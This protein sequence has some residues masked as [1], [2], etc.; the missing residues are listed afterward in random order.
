LTTR[1]KPARA[2]FLLSVLL[3]AIAGLWILK[4]AYPG[5]SAR[6]G[7]VASANLSQDPPARTM[8]LNG[9]IRSH[10]YESYLEIG[11]GRR[12]GNFDLI[13][14]RTRIGV[15]P[16]PTLHAAYQMTSDE[17]FAKNPASFDLIFIDGLHRADQV[18]RDILN[19]LRVL[20]DQGTIV[21]HDCNPI[22]EALQVVPRQADD[23]TGDVWKAWVRLRASRA[24]LE[25]FVVDIETGCGIIRRGRQET[26][27]LPEQL[28]YQPL[29]Q[30]RKQLLNLL[31]ADSGLEKLL[32][33]SGRGPR[34][35]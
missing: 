2:I 19:S 35:H 29:E 10:S 18:E 26:V 5:V 27:S 30:H 28:D 24:D 20:N 23:W 12:E 11:Q 34:D 14:C 32:G 17:F 9:L 21:V 1:G 33:P 4:T 7:V 15:D 16:D 3:N 31:S 8:I 13:R 22:T 6:W 25:M